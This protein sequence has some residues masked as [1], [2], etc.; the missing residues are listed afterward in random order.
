MNNTMSLERGPAEV[1]KDALRGIPV[2]QPQPL[3]AAS[4]PAACNLQP[5]TP[6]PTS[7][8]PELRTPHSG[9]ATPGN[10]QPSTFNL[11]PLYERCPGETP[12][13]YG[14]FMAFFELSH[15]RSLQAV[16]D[17]LGQDF[18]TVRN[19]SSRFNWSDRIQTFNSG[20]LQQQANAQ[21][22][23][24]AR[25]AADWAARLQNFREQEW[26][27]AQ[28]LLAAARCF[29]ESFGE[30]DLQKMTLAQVSRALK[31][32]S[33]IGRLALSGAELPESS[34]A[35]LS[36]VQHQLLNALKCVY[37]APE[38][39]RAGPSAPSRD[40]LASSSSSSSSVTASARLQPSTLS[41][42]PAYD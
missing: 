11:Q 40:E 38:V 13:A 10:L 37:G 33:A 30:D 27:A 16:A 25:Q 23:T 26:D 2:E 19:W 29:L 18:G 34:D 7:D 28:K 41:A 36:P 39:G 8:H 21:A 5:S 4:Q 15:S 20:L 24:H 1:G 35:S 3:F 42:Q 6:P 17:K 32:S 9:L 31:I 12:R 14:A 22:D